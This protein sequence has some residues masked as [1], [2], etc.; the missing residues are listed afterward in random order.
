YMNETALLLIGM[1]NDHFSPLSPV[2][3]MIDAPHRIDMVKDRILNLVSHFVRTPLTMINLPI[4]FHKGHPEICQEVGILAAIKNLGLFVDGTPG[5]CVIP[6]LAQWRERIITLRGRTGFNAFV[7]TSLHTYLAENHIKRLVFAGSTTAVCIDSTAR[8]GYELGYDVSVLR[9]C[10]VSRT[11]DEQD[12]YCQSIFPLY[13]TVL[14]TEQ[15]IA[16][17]TAN[18]IRRPISMAS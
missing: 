5:G 6:E 3:D 11:P 4:L 9:D 18:N 15:F 2:R 7:D 10:T 13:A 1:Q 12:M 16:T 8:S 17:L 14:N